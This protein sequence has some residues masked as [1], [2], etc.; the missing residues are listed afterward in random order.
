MTLP[1]EPLSVILHRFQVLHGHA[2]DNGVYSLYVTDYSL[3]P[4]ITPVQGVWCP[5]GLSEYVLKCEMWDDAAKMGKIMMA[6]EYYCIKNARMRVSLGGYVEGKIVEPKINKLELDP[7]EASRNPFLTALI[8]YVVLS[9]L[10]W[11]FTFRFAGEKR[12][13]KH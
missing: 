4:S 8:E 2:N 3:N 9:F 12:L 11:Y 6:G 7:Q 5:K 1:R 10:L 13:G